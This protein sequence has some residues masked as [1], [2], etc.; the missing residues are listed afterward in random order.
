MEQRKKSPALAE[1]RGLYLGASAL[2]NWGRLT[3]DEKLNTADRITRLILRTEPRSERGNEEK[4][5]KCKDVKHITEFR[6]SP[7][8]KSGRRPWCRECE[9]EYQREWQRKKRELRSCKHEHIK[10]S[11]DVTNVLIVEQEIININ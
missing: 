6:K 2:A 4:C 1:I 3:D 9:N 8:Y 11:A 7:V 5:K 10:S